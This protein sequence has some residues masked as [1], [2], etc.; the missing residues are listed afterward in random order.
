MNTTDIITAAILFGP[1]V[2]GLTAY[3]LTV[4]GA[5]AESA[6]VLRM[7]ADSAAERAAAQLADGSG[8]TPGDREPAPEQAPAPVVHLATVIDFP[9]RQAA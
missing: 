5:A 6:A 8:G 2:A 3:A 1:G 9:T 7:L 4:R